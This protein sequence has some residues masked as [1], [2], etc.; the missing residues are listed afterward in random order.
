MKVIRKDHWPIIMLTEEEYNSL[1]ETLYLLSTEANAAKL[2][3]SV[4]Q[5]KNNQFVEVE[6]N[7]YQMD[8]KR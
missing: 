1:N 6:L 8:N 7:E 3:E 4:Q 2:L 5:A